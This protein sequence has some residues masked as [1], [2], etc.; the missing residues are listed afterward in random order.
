[1]AEVKT[2]D[3][4]VVR[5]SLIVPS[6]VEVEGS[7][8]SVVLDSTVGV[9]D[10]VVDT[11]VNASSDV[12]IIGAVVVGASLVVSC[13]VTVDVSGTG[14][15]ITKSSGTSRTKNDSVAGFEPEIVMLRGTLRGLP[16]I[17]ACPASKKHDKSYFN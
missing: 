13:G 8:A 2:S 3:V 5:D 12:I 1:M 11:I 6:C 16:R 17:T 10:V 14:V 7:K 4:S 15:G 9:C